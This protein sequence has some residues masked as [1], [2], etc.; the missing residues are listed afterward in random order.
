MRCPSC[1]KFVAFEESDP[2]VDLEDNADLG[3]VNGTVRIVNACAE[4][5]E[6]LKEANFDIDVDV[7][8]FVNAHTDKDDEGTHEI[9]IE[10]GGFERDQRSEGKGRGAKT[11]YGASGSIRLSC[12][13]GENQ[14]VAWS[15]FVQASDMDE[16]V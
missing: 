15:D 3:T 14:D 8:E 11:F 9:S 10:E 12:K 16:L 5:G 2:E 7:S 6:E 13:C 4:C 1:N